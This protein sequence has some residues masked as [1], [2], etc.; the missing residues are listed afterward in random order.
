M[1]RP[2]HLAVLLPLVAACAPSSTI[3]EARTDRTLVSVRTLEGT[4]SL[5]LSRD[6]AISSEA[7]TTGA[8]AAWAALPAVYAQLEIPVNGIDQAKKLLSSTQRLRRI[9]GKGVSSFFSCPGPYGNLASSG[10]VYITLRSQ[11][12]P[13]GDSSTIRHMVDA[14]ARSSTGGSSQVRCTSNGSLEKLLT[15]T[16]RARLQG[17]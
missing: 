17:G 14:I 16:L 8:D 13:E 4:S 6:A 1:I 11:V 10:D 12:L 3:P 7:L 9:G 2:R 5:E 15:E